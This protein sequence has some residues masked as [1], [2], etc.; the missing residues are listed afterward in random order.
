MVGVSTATHVRWRPSWS[1]GGMSEVTQ[2]RTTTAFFAQAA[3][4]FGVAVVAVGIGIAYLPAS[5][6]V[7]GFLSVGVLYTITSAFTLAK[8]V[9]DQH[10]ASTVI[11]RVDQVRLERLLAEHDPYRTDGV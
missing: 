8:V 10:E 1:T 3:V 11:S 9:R 2:P 6:W 5:A 7:R 4:S